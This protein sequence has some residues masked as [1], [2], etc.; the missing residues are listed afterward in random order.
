MRPFLPA[1]P[2]HIA[3]MIGEKLKVN[4]LLLSLFYVP[5]L[6]LAQVWPDPTGEIRCGPSWTAR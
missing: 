4:P 3:D 1:T 2:Q 5:V 6:Y